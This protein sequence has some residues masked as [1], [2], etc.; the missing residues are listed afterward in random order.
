MPQLLGT[1]DPAS[2]ARAR[3]VFKVFKTSLVSTGLLEAELAK[4][5]DNV[6]RYVNF[7]LANEFM[8]LARK[9]GARVFEA[10]RAANEGYRRGGLPYPGFAAGP[11]LPKDSLLLLGGLPFS[12]LILSSW[13]LNQWLPE[14]FLDEVESLYG[15]KKAAILGLA[16]KGDS[17]DA[18][19]SPGLM[20]A[21]LLESRGILYEAHD[22]RVNGVRV[23]RSLKAT[24]WKAD[25]I[26]VMVPH[27]EYRALPW[28]CL[29]N[30]VK[31]GCV[32]VDPWDTWGQGDVLTFVHGN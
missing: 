13:R 26:F 17:D 25:A 6:F 14:Y 15:I 10:L 4:L 21:R 27:S 12:E 11:C 19:N 1:A 23:R 24:L 7:A 3:S 9:L 32:V 31:P 16:F 20:L 5:F 30:W 22:P 2:E 18:R 28:F 8:I 29:C